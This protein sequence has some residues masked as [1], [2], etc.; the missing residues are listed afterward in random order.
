MV[1]Q[2]E[3]KK[4]KS[5]RCIGLFVLKRKL[6]IEIRSN[7]KKSLTY[8]AEMRPKLPPNQSQNTP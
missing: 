5:D 4:E 8:S 2:E 6:K 3:M 7:L 1:E